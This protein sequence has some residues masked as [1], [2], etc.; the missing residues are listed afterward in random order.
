MKRIA[1]LHDYDSRPEP[2]T[3]R[4]CI[5]CQRDIKQGRPARRVLLTDVGGVP[6]KVVHPDDWPETLAADNEFAL[7]GM[8]CARKLG[9][10]WS[11]AEQEK[12]C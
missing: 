6:P 10:D 11:V 2:R 3:S 8:D 9:L 12:S 7:L 4:Y 5:N 1:Y